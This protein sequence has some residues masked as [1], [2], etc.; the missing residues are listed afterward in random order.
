MANVHFFEIADWL[1]GWFTCDI[2]GDDLLTYYA[3]RRQATSPLPQPP[4][5]RSDT[6]S[7]SSRRNPPVRIHSPTNTRRHRLE[8]LIP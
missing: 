3:Q 6:S 7:P 5:P 4:K 8:E 1:L 2:S